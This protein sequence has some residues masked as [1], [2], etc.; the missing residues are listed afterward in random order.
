MQAARDRAVEGMRE[1]DTH[2]VQT[3][4]GWPPR[5]GPCDECARGDV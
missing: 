2:P 5:R 3:R 4:D 1:D